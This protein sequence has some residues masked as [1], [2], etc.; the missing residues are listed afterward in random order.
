MNK[1]TAAATALVILTFGCKRPTIIDCNC[2]NGK[3]IQNATTPNVAVLPDIRTLKDM[4]PALAINVKLD[5]QGE[6]AGKSNTG[7]SAN[8][9][10][11]VN[12]ETI[13][14]SLRDNLDQSS[15][16]M[17]TSIKAALVGLYINPCDATTRKNFWDTI[18]DINSWG[19]KLN[20]YAYDVNTK[21]REIA[22]LT[23]QIKALN[24]KIQ[25]ATGNELDELKKQLIE[26]EKKL[27]Q[28][29]QAL[30]TAINALNSAVK[31]TSTQQSITPNL[32]QLPLTPS[33]PAPAK[34]PQPQSPSP[35]VPSKPDGK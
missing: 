10:A 5:T 30:D 20:E 34:P 7:Q 25:K 18:K 23:E 28:S 16:R 19:L 3:Q 26:R 1:P 17:E 32:P 4:F 24:E 2:I 6:I 15:I 22:T 27:Q 13:N 35:E 33:E 21:A 9:N 31:Q 12:L 11:N 8:A 29:N 14:K